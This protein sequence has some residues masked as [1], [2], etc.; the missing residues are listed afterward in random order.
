M[1]ELRKV[2]EEG[3]AEGVDIG[4]NKGITIAHH[5]VDE[6]IDKTEKRLVGAFAVRPEDVWLIRLV[7]D[8]LREDLKEEMR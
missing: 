5:I 3:R 1:S 8:E 6:A 7:L 4:V 2:Y